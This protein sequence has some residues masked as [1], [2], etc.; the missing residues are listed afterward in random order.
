MTIQDRALS[1]DRKKLLQ[2]LLRKKGIEV[3]QAS[4]I[5]R[6]PGGGPWRLSFSQ[7]RLWF[8]DQL[9]PGSAAYNIPYAVR[10]VGPLDLPALRRTFDELFRRHEALRTT[11]QF[12][13]GRP[14]QAVSRPR[15]L[16]VP[17]VDLSTLAGDR[18]ESA[19]LR[20]ADQEAGR[21]FELDLGPLL[22]VTLAR[23]GAADHAV[24][25]TL[26]HIVGDGWS[27]GLLMQ[28]AAVIY[29][30][31]RQRRPSP[32]PEAPLQYP[33]FAEWQR[34]RLGGDA[35]AAEIAYW[36]DQ[37][38][39]LPP[40][41]EL[42]T[43]RPRP[44]VQSFRGGTRPVRLA[45]ALRAELLALG[46]GQRTTLFMT[47]LAA[48][49]A[50]L[51]RLSGQE[52]FAIGTPIAGRKRTE[53]EGVVGFFVNTLVLRVDLSGD[54]SF[55]ELLDRVRTT[56][57]GAQAHQDL[58]LGKL[59]QE[60]RPDRN[61]AHNALF[62]VMF[63]LE[64]AAPAREASR[65]GELALHPLAAS[66]ATA[67]VD[68]T[69]VL[70][71]GDAAITG[72]AE[73]STDLFNAAT[74]DRWSGHLGTLLA[75]VVSD[76]DRP[77]SA[78]PLLSE[79]E[80][81]QVLSEWNH[82]PEGR[83]RDRSVQELFGRQAAQT[84]EAVAIRSE[85]GEL[86]YGELE[87]RANALARE[88]TEHGVGP[89]E[90]VGVVLE[91]SADL[92]VA[93]LA[94]LKAGGAYL[95]LDPEHP[96]E[97]LAYMLEDAGA[98][99]LVSR[100]ALLAGLPPHAGRVVL[101][102]AVRGEATA[103]PARDGGPDALA[104]VI[105]TS[106]S[107]GRPKGV[108]VSHR[109]IVRLVVDANYVRLG[110]GRRMA[111][112][113]T[114]AFDAS[115]FE[116]WG[117]LLN[118]GCLVIIPREVMLSPRDLA[119]RL[120]AER[121]DVAFVTTA[122]FHQ[123]AVE[124]PEGFTGLEALL[125]GGE[126]SDPGLVRRLLLRGGPGRLLHVYGP[127]EATTYS[128]WF[129]VREVSPQAVAV[130]IGRPVSA[131][132][133]YVVDRE[134]RAVPPGVT[135]EL[136]V[137]GP[138]LAR[139]YLGRP[140]L[141][142]E[143]FLPNPFAHLPGERV[144]RTGDL[145]RFLATG[146][147]EFVGR[148]DHQVKL[149]GFRIEL[150]EV[151]SAL[152][153]QADVQEAVVIARE[154]TRGDRR[155]VAYVVASGGSLPVSALREG[156]RRRLPEYMLPA[157][158]VFLDALPMTPSG[159]VDRKALPAPERVSGSEAGYLAPRTPSEQIVAGVFAEVLA[160]EPV[161][162]RGHF[163][164]LGGHSL[165]ATQATS[166]LRSSF[167]V[168]LPLRV[169]FESPTVEALAAVLD[170]EM[171]AGAGLLAPPI[172]PVAREG[173]LPLS[174]AQ[175]RLWFIDQLEPGSPLYNIPLALWLEGPLD[176][177]PLARALTEVVRRHEALRTVFSTE[178]GIPFQVISP[179]SA[180]PLPVVDLSGLDA[181]RW[182][183][184]LQAHQA[185]EAARP[186]DL[187]R[188]PLVRATLLRRSAVE[189]AALLTL[190]HVIGDGWSLGVLMQ[191]VTSLYDAF[192]SG[193]SSPLPE[194]PV[195]YA[196]FAVWQRGWL[197]GEVLER[198]LGYWKE[199]LAGAPA[200]LELPTDRPRPAVQTNRGRVRD[201]RLTAELASGLQR[202]G[203]QS[204]ATLFMVLL[205]GFQAV[206]G[207]WSGQ[208]DLCVGMPIAGRNHLEIEGLIGFFVNTLVL[209]VDLSG[210]ASFSALLAAVREAS[211]E[212]HTHQEVPFEKLVEELATQRS[213][214]H[215]PLFQVMFNLV[216]AAPSLNSPAGL[217]MGPLG[218]AAEVA[219]FELSLALEGAEDSTAGSLEYNADLFDPSTI[220]RL[221]EDWL[222]LLSAAVAR[223][224]ENLI[225]LPALPAA[226][227][228][229]LATE[230]QGP[231]RSTPMA[232]NVAAAFARRVEQSAEQTAVNCDGESVSF[233]ELAR[234]VDG[235]A[236]RLRELGVGPDSLVGLCVERSVDMIVGI[237]GILQ[238]GGAYVPLDPA[239]P[240]ERL[241][242]MLADCGA[243]HVVLQERLT[244]RCPILPGQRA[245]LLD[246][247]AD[248]PSG[249]VPPP[250]VGP[251]HAAYV[252]Y[253]SGSTGRPKGVVVRQGA[254]LNLAM[255]LREG[256]YGEGEA[257][258]RVG[259]NASMTFDGSVKQIVQILW[260]HTLC[261]LPESV[262]LDA[263]ACVAYLEQE[264]ID[265][266]DSTPS[267]LKV[268]LA[269]GLGRGAYP[270]LMLI[271]GEALDAETW[272]RAQPTGIRFVNVYGPT[273]CTV[274]ATS[275]DFALAGSVAVIG[276]PLANVSAYVVGSAGKLLPV[277]VAGELWIGGAGVA[278]GYLGRP[279]L[280][281]ERF[282]PDPFG[283]EPGGR[284][285][286]TGDR[287]RCRPAG[288]IEFWA[289]WIIR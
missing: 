284:L 248:L 77:V 239:Y 102:D 64:P 205:A 214:S 106:G 131:T 261:P 211:L 190:H 228:H 218:G 50:L 21:P 126:V 250:R 122:L 161:G 12:A 243:R 17:F 42:P 23:V 160:V 117:A 289:A 286:R 125:F 147:V 34:D 167:G 45:G 193:R 62:Q 170:Q 103:A 251:D 96:A 152:R 241:A 146:D 75:G 279:D 3:S 174:F 253:T 272:E 101:V 153:E 111:Q 67:K 150:G 142:A 47:V 16:E 76:P 278:R 221:I 274:D 199:R 105:Y 179:A 40:R 196:D 187:A 5:V 140:D 185:A 245:V 110:A 267:Q 226:E 232:A 91:R 134:L 246:H 203:R 120:A 238:A 65:F 26:H 189:H 159:K 265:V 24:L 242:W 116:V 181:E 141:T 128:S 48:F 95:P 35:L 41:L 195:Q 123:M 266:V 52:D 68:L 63:S 44:L 175:Q 8:I 194:L 114:P 121:I 285:Y 282:L 216:H 230:W 249:P 20:L 163:F 115:T 143:R 83:W 132:P 252:I 156:L 258:L 231:V 18:R 273:E 73:F 164:E 162:A 57:L 86:T 247:P 97:R 157:A 7:E 165:L 217:R 127:T 206:L 51:G 113:A 210:A 1:S 93:L 33:D 84:P 144:Y 269:S 92:V 89:E 81:W 178:A 55:R 46:R 173:S 74:V 43:D 260:G 155:L 130:P 85:G 229:L 60:I 182:R 54:P 88:L 37:L 213:L 259:I 172:V 71:E 82:T 129:P 90:R 275:C 236:G 98:R 204:G 61:L 201:V 255:A 180:F 6:R 177:G 78:L 287:V 14:L 112:I 94:V 145:C 19:L 233:R 224:E 58:P 137:G 256:V 31:F 59:A 32:L 4:A 198:E 119:A 22:R 139:G 168:E 215:S 70:T 176:P 271:G 87:G 288:Q 100:R 136:L 108:A 227:R 135:G 188:G 281:A 118:G 15:S 53:L 27:M 257:A 277:G 234:R 72:W 280:T 38:Q 29:E 192:A 80:R 254:V 276:P 183:S 69:L 212:A 235:L 109:G 49:Q 28:E 148:S 124:A 184:E 39:E 154:D 208:S 25:L 171:R 10:L 264:R 104:Y 244:G 99:V 207:R 222:Q 220:V 263:A 56:T 149:R 107:T 225:D 223:P 169:L 13:D 219:K 9:E 30:A 237:L 209:R 268:L 2:Q 200:L 191:E 158:W 138:G 262:R 283:N 240:Q 11:F 133:L 151:E 186:F 79:P 166:R 270:R 66:N 202:L 36:R 197:S